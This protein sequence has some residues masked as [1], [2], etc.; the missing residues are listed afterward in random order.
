MAP[1]IGTWSG[2]YANVVR[3]ERSSELTLIE[4]PASIQSDIKNNVSPI[5]SRIRTGFLA[6][7]LF[8]A[9]INSTGAGAPHFDFQRIVFVK[10]TNLQS[11][12]YYTD[13]INGGFEPGGNLCL[14]D[15]ET[16]QTREVVSELKGGVFG[17]FDLSFDARTVVFAWKKS[18]DT[19]YRIYECGIDGGGLRQLTFPPAE[20][21][22]LVKKYQLGYHHGTDDMDPCYLPDGGICF[23]STRCQ[24]GILCDSPDI[25]T[26]TVLYRMDGNG[27]NIR[28]LSNSS[29]SEATPAVMNDGRMLYTRWEYV[30]KG[31]VSVKC[32]W[33]MNPDGSGSS[34]IYGADIALP[35]TFTQGRPIPGA[36][37]L[38]I[39]AG[40]PHCPQN[41]VGTIIRIDISKDIRTREPMTYIT[42]DVDVRA[43]GGFWFDPAGKWG[44]RLFKDPYPI[45]EKL[46]L[47]SL[48]PTGVAA[49]KVNWGIC[50]LD[51]TGQTT[52]LYQDPQYGSF[53]PIPVKP[54]RQPPVIATRT[55]P[56]L[57]AM[58]KAACIITDVYRG[59]EGIQR[60]QA[61]YLRINEQVPRPWNARRF[62]DGDEYDQQHAVISK[63]ASLGLKVQLGIVPIESDGS[64][65]FLVPADRNIYFQVL[66]A[67]FMEL[68]RERTYVNYRPGERR[69][70]IGCHET[71]SQA[72]LQ[73]Q[74]APLALAR[75]PS[76]PG[77]QPGEV[78]GARPLHYPTDVQ[79]IWD[80][81]CLKC[82]SGSA[83]K[84]D[85]DLSGSLTT[86]FNTSYESLMP[87]RRKAPNRDRR[88]LGPIIGE[89]HPKTG[90]IDYLPARS[91]GSH[92]SVLVAMLSG[93][94]V[95]LSNPADAQRASTLAEKHKEIHLSGEELLRI[96]TWVEANGQYYGSYYGKRNI[97]YKAD[98]D[99]RPVPTFQQATCQ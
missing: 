40:T 44:H 81:Y 93:G 38:F 53:M 35:P 34:E 56:D 67:N 45:S 5:A 13:Y 98:Q 86:F 4:A 52:L 2:G 20:E 94:K 55:D 19:G 48:N 79:P 83:P 59:L 62:Y 22:E 32:L 41:A 50:S 16:G 21:A 9:G 99:F 69:S 29:V 92:T 84:G 51:E 31:A 77:P 65:Y 30:D 23:I 57:A 15:L 75:L 7:G 49:E 66:D 17:R 18:A 74:T 39:A 90:N 10:R 61:K 76:E 28:K 68:Q 8:C 47:V 97:R 71:P 12:H 63:D 80:K 26:T 87:E 24:Y 96:T 58:N 54:R 11:N 82:H 42:P 3:I 78:A 6:V 95:H 33:A 89:N 85:L 70:C 60:G 73:Q 64:A 27:G 1:G 14:L 72:P 43:E 36:D 88:V 37:N 46:F 25:F 91:L